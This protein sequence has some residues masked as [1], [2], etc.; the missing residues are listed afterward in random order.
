MCPVLCHLLCGPPGQV[1]R[2]LVMAVRVS[3]SC[4][5][6]PQSARCQNERKL[7][8]HSLEAGA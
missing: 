1:L 8:S 3:Y 6:T 5:E 7:L 2:H 4:C